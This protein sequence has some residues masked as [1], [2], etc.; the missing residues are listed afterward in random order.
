MAEQVPEGFTPDEQDKK[1]QTQL[2]E[3]MDQ[4][5]TP[6]AKDRLAR[7]RL[8]N[9]KKVQALQMKIVEQARSGVLREKITEEKLCEMLEEGAS[10]VPK[11][12][13]M[14]RKIKGFDDDDEDDNDDD[15][16]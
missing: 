2:A 16:M 15:L 4:I 7:V 5:L 12:T 9:E 8:V 10:N 13:M 3:M 14:R 11:V 6:E 1:M